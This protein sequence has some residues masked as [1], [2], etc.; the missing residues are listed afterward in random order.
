VAGAGRLTLHAAPL[1]DT[2]RRSF[3][4]GP[5]VV[6]LSGGADSA[7]CAWAACAASDDRVRAV[8]ADHGLPASRA[9]VEAAVAIAKLLEIGHEIVDARSDSESEAGLRSAR[10]AAIDAATRPGEALVS[11]HTADDQAETVLGNLIRGA[12]ASGLAGIPVARGRWHRPLLGVTREHTRAAAAELSLPFA[13]DPGNT[14]P[15]IRR[16]RIRTEVIPYLEGLNPSVRD[17]LVR[18]ARLAGL[19]DDAFAARAAAIPVLTRHGEVLIAASALSTAPRAVASRAVRRGLRRVLDPYAGDLAATEAVLDVARGPASSASISTGLIATRE[20]PWVVIH[21]PTLSEPIEAMQL[22]V[23]GEVVFGR[24]WISAEPVDA[25]PSASLSRSSVALRGS[26]DLE[27]RAARPGDTISMGEGSK[28]VVD[29]LR[30]A[31]VPARLRSMWPV[32]EQAGTMVWVAG[33]RH[34]AGAAADPGEPATMLRMGEV[35]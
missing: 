1:L 14:D 23:P 5:I 11:G 29:A 9:L 33:S 25:A 10:Y 3:P 7:V 24:W 22:D 6:A 34:A 31:G 4:S 13:D 20:G 16:S 8:T 18:A 21:D 28:S 15:A 26:G 19:D 30:E 2:V 17:A 32:V 35:T 12:G 27:I